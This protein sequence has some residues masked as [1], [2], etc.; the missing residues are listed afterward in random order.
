MAILYGVIAA[1]F[2]SL[3]FVLNEVMHS[4][5]GNWLWTACLRFFFMLPFF[6]CFVIGR[7]GKGLIIF[8]K[9][10]QQPWR[11]ILWSQVGFGAF[12]VPLTFASTLA[13][14]WL[15]A[16]TWQITIVAGSLCAPFLTKDPQVRLASRMTGRDIVAF[17]SILLGILL[18]ELKQLSIKT[19]GGS[20]LAFWFVLFAAFAYPIG[21]RKIM[22]VNQEQTPELVTGDRIFAMIV[23]SLPTWLICAGI[24][25]YQSGWPTANQQV[26]SFIVALSSGVIATF[27]FFY[28]TQL[29][30]NNL[31]KLATIEAT[32][33]LEVLFSLLLGMLFLHSMVPGYLAWLGVVC[34]ILGV[35][36]K[37]RE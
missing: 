36:Y 12:Y 1:F 22:Q 25:Y 31:A 35:V 15:I 8:Q 11:W 9:V 24:A 29:V 16:S 26:S 2:F 19:G 37:I 13:P 23:C 5:G 18:I 20:L 30:Q 21:N 3:T 7:K 32:Q 6:F 28:A 33:S 4:A 17:G 14:G 10:R 34:I 27:L